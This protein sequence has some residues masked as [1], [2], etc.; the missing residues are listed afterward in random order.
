M[1]TDSRETAVALAKMHSFLRGGTIVAYINGGDG[2]THEAFRC[3]GGH[4][5]ETPEVESVFS[6]T[7][8]DVIAESK[9]P[10]YDGGVLE[11]G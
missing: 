7:A 9:T 10:P 2:E 11:S 4:I 1:T 6:I 8:P 3:T 5:F